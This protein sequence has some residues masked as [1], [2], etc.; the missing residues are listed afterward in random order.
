M[1]KQTVKKIGNWPLSLLGNTIIAITFL[2]MGVFGGMTYNLLTGVKVNG[3]TYKK[4]IQVKDL[5]ADILPPPEYIIESHLSVSQ[6]L[7]ATT[8]ESRTE[9]LSNLDRVEKEFQNR[10]E[11]W[12]SDTLL[13]APLHDLINHEVF[14]PAQK[15]YALLHSDFLPALASGDQQRAHAAFAQLNDIYALHRAAVDTLVSQSLASQT[16][17]ESEAGK[18]VKQFDW[19]VACLLT[20]SLAMV[21]LVVKAIMMGLKD[22]LG[23]DPAQVEGI[24]ERVIR[25]DLQETNEMAPASTSL[26]G[27]AHAMRDHLRKTLKSFSRMATLLDESAI[28][29]QTDARD[30]EKD[31][32]QQQDGAR[33]MSAAVEELSVSIKQLSSSSEQ[34]VKLARG[35]R[36]AS[37][38]GG[39][40]A[41]H[42]H[43]VLR[44]TNAFAESLMTNVNALN[45]NY[46][47][48]EAITM[49]I[50]DVA[51]QTNLLALNAAIEAARAGDTG[52]G[53]AV[54]ADEVRGLSARTRQSTREID[55]I[56]AQISDQVA[57][58]V[59]AV[60]QGVDLTHKGMTSMDQV[61]G[62][63]TS[64]LADAHLLEVHSLEVST[65]LRQQ[66]VATQSLAEDICHLSEHAI[67]QA[68]HAH[69]ATTS[70]SGMAGM[71]NA[72]REDLRHFALG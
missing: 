7:L 6:A 48:I 43:V 34:Q 42:C 23:G 45:Q 41:Q 55:T 64:L 59:D 40:M 37:E 2:A 22:R 36:T 11:F 31:A 12:M 67:A 39:E 10:H 60:N 46:K 70:A 44:N 54:V 30:G 28:K 50:K 20:A 13:D 9:W 49:T 58:I 24:L 61:N 32:L 71:A 33:N 27:R 53:F 35:S 1:F 17:I 15:Y 63:M 69:L 21:V 19:M 3:E 14:L 47:R 25:G 26:L 18:Q 38:R 68:E 57:D 52:R 66:S 72:M 29:L 4:I 51:E 62:A 56:V 16:R 65:A 5:V 8:P